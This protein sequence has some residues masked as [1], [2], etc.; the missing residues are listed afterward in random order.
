MPARRLRAGFTLIELSIVIFI[1]AIIATIA[2]PRIRDVMRTELGSTTR[3]L[4]NASRFLYEEATLRGTVLALVV[5]LERQAY[6]VARVDPATGELQP[7]DDLLSKPVIM[8]P[9]V[10]I[11][12][13]VLPSV[14]KLSQGVASTYFYPEGWADAAVIHIVDRNRD[15]YTVRIDPV[16][17]KGEV[18]EGYKEFEGS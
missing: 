8:P 4:S 18:L 1:I 3:R 14:G 12:D 10:R 6:W 15:A 13:V 9:D 17:G 16:R 7:D 11:A 5:D 2:V